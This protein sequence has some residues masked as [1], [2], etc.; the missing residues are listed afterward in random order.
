[1]AKN[2]FD[3][4]SNVT[5]WTQGAQSTQYRNYRGGYATPIDETFAGTSSASS[6]IDRFR[7]PTIGAVYKNSDGSEI[8]I[9][10]LGSRTALYLK[11][12]TDT[13]EPTIEILNTTVGT[14]NIEISVN[15]TDAESG[16]D[17]YKFY[18]SEYNFQDADFDDSLILQETTSYGS[19]CTFEGL[20][21]NQTYYIK[22]EVY[23]G[24]GK[25]ATAYT[26]EIK[27]NV[28][29]ITEDKISVRFYIN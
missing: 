13:T 27:T 17:K 15:A 5:E 8:Q 28:V 26:E 18:I 6:R 19:T 3:L 7:V 24:T 14:N 16:I 2:I 12:T 10:M 29:E 1:M 21:Q 23:N 20:T 9:N 22:A 25:V 4:A 11:H